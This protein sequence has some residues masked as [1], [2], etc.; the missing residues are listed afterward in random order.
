MTKA[1]GISSPFELFQVARALTQLWPDYGKSTTQPSN[2]ETLNNIN[3]R[4]T[5]WVAGVF[6]HAAKG[7]RIR[8]QQT[9]TTQTYSLT[10]YSA[11]AGQT[12]SPYSVAFEAS[13]GI[14]YRVTQAGFSDTSLVG[15]CRDARD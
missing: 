1:F 14:W 8:A 13:A 5:R 15:E 4:M 6:H 2:G 9:H 3:E 11:L 12:R 7:V 10:N